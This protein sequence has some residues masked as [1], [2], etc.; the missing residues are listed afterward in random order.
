M[1]ELPTRDAMIGSMSEPRTGDAVTGSMRDL[2][3]AG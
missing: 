1:R 2:A 3:D